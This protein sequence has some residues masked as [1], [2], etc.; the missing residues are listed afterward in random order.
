MGAISTLF[1]QSRTCNRTNG[2]GHAGSNFTKTLASIAA[3]GLIISSAGFGA[4]WAA[5]AGAAHGPLMAGLMVLFAV[6]LEISKP[7]SAAA[8]FN[9]FRRFAIVRGSALAL[10][11]AVACAYSLTAELSLMAGA[12]G[13]LIARRTA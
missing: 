12:R 9:A 3:A 8:A 1:R 2:L 13:D 4:V 10:L 5:T 11:A 6:G 7:L